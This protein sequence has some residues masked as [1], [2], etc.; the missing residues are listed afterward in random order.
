VSYTSVEHVFWNNFN[1]PCNDLVPSAHAIKTWIE[2]FKETGSTLK[3]RIG[4]VKSVHMP[5]NVARV[6]GALQRSPTLSACWH[7]VSPGISDCNARGFYRKISTTICVR[8][9]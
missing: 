9:R 2:K 3:K 6:E 4:S 1:I 8:F 5:E 7:T